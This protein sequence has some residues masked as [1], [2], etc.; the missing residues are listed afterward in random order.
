[1]TRHFEISFND[2]SEEFQESMV[3]S[4]LDSLLEAAKQEGETALARDWHDPKPKTWQE[5]YVRES[6][7]DH[8]YWQA[9]ERQEDGAETSEEIDWQYHLEEHFR[10]IAETACYRGVKHME[11]E[12]EL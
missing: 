11:I 6:A 3:Q 5:A 2:L 10:K 12:V 4:C 7:I 1:M 9:Y 8:T